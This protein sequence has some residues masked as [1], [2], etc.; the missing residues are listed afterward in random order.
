MTPRQQW[1]AEIRLRM[2]QNGITVSEL[3][4]ALRTLYP[5]GKNGYRAQTVTTWLNGEVDTE[6]MDKIDTII[7]N[8]E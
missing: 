6:I 8:W 2:L 1:G 4:K 3:A 7:Y 5:N